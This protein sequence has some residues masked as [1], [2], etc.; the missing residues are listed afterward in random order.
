MKPVLSNLVHACLIAVVLTSPKQ[1][2]SLI[3]KAVLF[4]LFLAAATSHI[5]G[6]D[7][8]LANAILTGSASMSAATEAA[9]LVSLLFLSLQKCLLNWRLLCMKWE[10]FL[11]ETST[12]PQCARAKVNISSRIDQT[13]EQWS[14]WWW[15]IYS[16]ECVL[17]HCVRNTTTHPSLLCI[18]RNPI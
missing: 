14:K 5:M 18:T 17:P 2:D 3:K 9:L 11:K 8:S 7:S 6:G 12:Y 16:C 4:Q 15:S 13:N 1:R 10:E